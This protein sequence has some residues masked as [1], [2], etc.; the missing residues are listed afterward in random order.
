MK[1]LR[2]NITSLSKIQSFLLG[3]YVCVPLINQVTRSIFPNVIFMSM[4]YFVLIAAIAISV[5]LSVTIL[6]YRSVTYD[7]IAVVVL[8]VIY[9]VVACLS[10]NSSMSSFSAISY[11]IAPLVAGAIVL[12]DYLT[13]IKSILVIATFAFIY[14]NKFFVVDTNGYISMGLSYIC[15][16]P[17]IAAS[18][19]ISFCYSKDKGRGRNVFLI[20]SIAQAI[21]LVKL[22]QYG[23]RGPILSIILC[24]LFISV[25]RY[26]DE[27]KC[28]TIKKTKIGFGLFVVLIF[29]WQFYNVLLFTNK[30][31]IHYGISSQIIEKPL[32]LMSQSGILNSRDSIYSIALKEIWKRPILG[33]GLSSF[34]AYTGINYPH[35]FLIQLLFDGGIFLFSIIVGVLIKNSVIWF[36]KC[37]YNTFILYI[38]LFF[39][40][41]PGALF[42]GDVWQNE[43]FWLFIGLVISLSIKDR[44]CIYNNEE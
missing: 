29:V 12:I 23:S 42:S 39:I 24:W 16:T 40:S 36:K 27:Y 31:I 11:V 4:I 41:I 37:S 8:I 17:I 43:R 9:C 44:W 19:Y 18:L 13:L 35:S 22:F 14:I 38:L 26:N 3:A 5:L 25:I 1:N 28:I 30:I 6:N 15:L 7:T 20:F 32:R 33:H 2:L 21:Y 10:Q 34:E